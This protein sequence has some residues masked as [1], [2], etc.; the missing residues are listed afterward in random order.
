MQRTDSTRYGVAN[1]NGELRSDVAQTVVSFDRHYLMLPC[2]SFEA[3]RQHSPARGLDV[4]TRVI[5]RRL[6]LLDR[7]RVELDCE[8]TR[9]RLRL[10]ALA[11]PK[12]V[13]IDALP[14]N[15]PL[16][17]DLD[18]LRAL[19][20]QKSQ[21]MLELK[22]VTELNG[23]LELVAYMLEH[24]ED[25]LR[26]ELTAL[27]LDR[28]GVVQSEQAGQEVTRV[29]VEEILLGPDEPV[30]RVVLPVHI[31]RQSI[32]ELERCVAAND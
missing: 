3:L 8:L 15:D 21:R 12:L 20:E 22:T 25:Y 2:P 23:L 26:V 11:N 24:P 13:L 27:S 1:Q 6:E 30:H 31:S 32:S 16:P 10:S 17:L 19:Q 18:A 4:L 28:M 5:A 7:E 14:D 29:C 9:I